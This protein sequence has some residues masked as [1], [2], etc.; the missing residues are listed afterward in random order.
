MKG[1]SMNAHAQ[2]IQGAADDLE[3]SAARF[4]DT[5]FTIGFDGFVDEILH[6][7]SLR[8]GQ[9]DY[10]RI[11]TIGEFS[12]RIAAAAGKSANIEMVPQQVKPGGNGPLMS[13]AVSGMGGKVTCIGLLGHPNR[14]PVFAPLAEGGPIELISVGNPGRTDAVEFLDGKI[15][16]GKLDTIADANWKRL[17]SEVGPERLQDLVLKS[18]LLACT[19]WTMLTGMEGILEGLIALVKEV[20]EQSSVRFFFDLADPEKRERADLARALGQIRRLNEKARCVLGLNLREAEQVG[21]VLGLRAKLSEDKNGLM[22]AAIRIAEAAGLHGVVVHAVRGA[23]ASLGGDNAAVDGPYCP[24]PKLSTGAGDHFNG[25]FVS[26]LLS[27][28]D[29]QGALYAGVGTSGWYVRNARTPRRA[30]VIALLR[31]WAAGRLD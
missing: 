19:N 7:V 10:D 4:A 2:A 11:R 5:R 15:M 24:E 23:G 22:E 30:E 18:D 1:A 21:E 26:G 9:G 31:D 8:R 13:M 25:G 12:A 29:T 3:K 14:H 27:G 20:P 28:L 16:F 6:A 17:L